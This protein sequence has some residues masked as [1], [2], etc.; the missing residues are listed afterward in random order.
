MQ[1]RPYARAVPALLAEMENQREADGNPPQPPDPEEAPE[2]VVYVYPL[3]GGGVVFTDTPIKEDV[4]Q[5]QAPVIDA[6]AP[7]TDTHPAARREPAYFLHLLLILCVFVG[8]DSLDALFA[9]LAPT[10]TITLTPMVKTVSTTATINV[11]SGADIEGRILPPLTLSQEQTVPAT[12]RGHQDA[13][14][15]TGTQIY[16]NGAFSPQTI[17]A[18]TV[19]AGADGVQV[20]TDAAVT[21]PAATPG[22]PP[23]FGQATVMAHA[24]RAGAGGNIRAGDISIT[25]SALQVSNGPFQGGQDA[26]DF[27]TVTRADIDRPAAM[28]KAQVT[29]SMQ[30]ALGQQIAPGEQLQKAPCAPAIAADPAIGQEA[31]NVRVT[32]S[33]TCSGFAYHSQEL[34]AR[35]AKLLTAQ[36]ART[37][38]NGYTRY[39]DIAVSVM[40]VAITGQ[41]AVLAFTCQGT[42]VYHINAARIEALVNGKPRLAALQLLGRFPGIARASIGG[43]ADNQE[44][45]TDMTHIHVLVLF[46]TV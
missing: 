13:L 30:A 31:S 3:E 27:T 19:Y 25:G 16:F 11:G 34:T 15:A 36:A 32:V 6:E 21:I 43:I 37:L 5:P 17:D 23:Q 10:V 33:E 1:A 8:L 39:G 9:S 45:P 29:Q 44:L 26:R 46:P 2:K 38:G 24:I 40:K 42:W 35:G 7:K 22:N 18:G 28:L 41:T 20:A 4:Q 12:G 14:P